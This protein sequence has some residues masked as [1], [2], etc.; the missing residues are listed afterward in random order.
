ME[1]FLVAVRL[2]EYFYY[3]IKQRYICWFLSHHR[4][5]VVHSVDH[6]PG[7]IKS[8][9]RFVLLNP[10]N[11]LNSFLVN[12]IF[13][14]ILLLHYINNLIHY[15]AVST[16]H[17]ISIWSYNITL[18]STRIQPNIVAIFIFKKNA[19]ISKAYWVR[20]NQPWALS[21]IVLVT[22]GPS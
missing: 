8:N 4:H 9:H 11:C 16:L 15:L 18:Y 5:R 12:I 1:L 20:V 10:I 6:L 3:F 14:E 22:R 21:S 19:I 17:S 13:W 7:W 2:R